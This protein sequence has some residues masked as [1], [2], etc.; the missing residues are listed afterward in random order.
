M[1]VLLRRVSRTGAAPTWFYLVAAAGFVALAAWAAVQRDWLI[2]VVAVAMIAAT[3][4]GRQLMGK[5]SASLRMQR[6][7]DDER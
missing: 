4:A 7:V 6:E 5:V 3:V 1:L 2:A